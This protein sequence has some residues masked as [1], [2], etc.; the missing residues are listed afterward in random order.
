MDT[1]FN[2]SSVSAYV[3]NIIGELAARACGED[4]IDFGMGNP[5][6]P[7]PPHIVSCVK[8]LSAAIRSYSQSKGIPNSVRR[9]ATGIKIFG[10]P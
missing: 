6:Q 1:H 7:T 2:A 8:R 9:S 10:V 4:I 3:F 5:D